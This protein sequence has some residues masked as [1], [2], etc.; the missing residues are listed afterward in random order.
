MST[1]YVATPTNMVAQVASIIEGYSMGPLRALAQEPVQNSKDEK[2]K[3][4]VRVEYRLHRR[5]SEDGRAYHLLTVSDSGTGGL[6]GP[7]LTQDELEARGHQLE[8]GENWAA[9]EGQGFTEKTGGE[10]GSRGQGKS[11]LLYHSDPQALLKDRRERCLMLYDTLLENGKYRLGVRYANPSDR[12][13]SPPLYGDEARAAIQGEYPVSD[14]L[15]VSLNLEPLVEPGTRVIVP[16]LKQSVMDAIQDGELHKWLQKCWWRAIQVGDL[17]IVVV[18]QDETA[19]TIEVPSWWEGSPWTQGDLRYLVA[20][21]IPV[22]GGLKIKR[23][24]L[25]HD[26]ELERDE[27]QGYEAQYQGVQLLRNQQWIETQ[28]IRDHVPPEHRAGFRGFAEFDKKLEL[29]LKESERPQHESFDGRY[30]SVSRVRQ[31]IQ[32]AVEEL[33]QNRGWKKVT[34]THE[35]TGVDQQ[36]A[37]DF[38]ATF[39]TTGKQKTRG[40]DRG[41]DTTWAPV[42]DWKCQLALTF[43]DPKTARVNWGDTLR[44]VTATVDANPAPEHRWAR[45]E[46][47]LTR[48]GDRTPL[49]IQ[50][51]DVE[52]LASTQIARFGDFKI[53]SGRAGAGQLF[54]PEPDIYQLRAVLIHNGRRVG[55]SMRRL[56]LGVDPPDAPNT[57]PYTV[58]ISAKNLTDPSL[59]RFRSGDEIGVQVTVKN[60]TAEDVELLLDASLEDLLICD[61][62]R[63]RIDGTPL[64]DTP[65]VKMGASERIRL[66]TTNRTQQ[67]RMDLIPD[68]RRT[69]A[70]TLTLEPGLYYVRADLRMP[71]SEEVIAHASTA[72]PFEVDPAGQ[73]QD[74]PFSIEGIEE[75]GSHPMWDLDQRTN[76]EWVLRYPVKYPIYDELPEPNRSSSKLGGRKAF[77][78]EICANGLVEWSLDALLTGDGS[79]FEILKESR[80]EGAD[81]ATWTG[82][83]ERL[84]LLEQRFDAQRR[85]SPREYDRLRR[86]TVADMLH[87]F[88]GLN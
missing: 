87:I 85:D 53:V 78:G 50:S 30:H 86:Q 34:R 88:Q 18:D 69:G 74:L 2:K 83:C 38:L 21:D 1:Q 44:E 82:Y 68:P 43:P 12:I 31:A 20:E 16:F 46:M 25:F 33:S 15:T 39:A 37:E 64:G 19:R 80:P 79:R 76:G 23:I 49:R 3:K 29:R 77:I 75:N 32:R 70:K 22:D 81:E 5:Q 14:D 24:V 61:G 59:R 40:N 4:Q 60:R 10:G 66:Q 28:D 63:V 17:E 56:Y 13:Q 62:R 65:N 55:T 57:N 48:D 27:I 58:S 47:E 42:T 45:V 71:G 41:T 8:D 67:M 52:M 9:F 36:H 51:M 73:R 26:P 11:A 7:V 35:A 54:C 72:I 84:E 6:K